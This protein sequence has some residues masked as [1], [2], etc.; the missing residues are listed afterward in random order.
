VVKVGARVELVC[1][2]LPSRNGTQARAA[3]D[4]ELEAL[5]LL[6]LLNRGSLLAPFHNMMLVSPATTPAQVV[7]LVANF[8]AAA[9]LLLGT[10]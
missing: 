5:L 7:S 1:A 4:H 3:M 10:S 8:D 2:P 9:G 6:M